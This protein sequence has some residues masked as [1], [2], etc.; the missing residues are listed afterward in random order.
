L[1]VMRRWFCIFPLALLIV[2]SAVGAV[3]PTNA[4][5]TAPAQEGHRYLF[6][7]DGSSGM[8][9]HSALV[10]RAVRELIRSG[11]HGRM[12]AGDEFAVWTYQ[13]NVR[14]RGFPPVPWRPEERDE[15][16]DAAAQYLKGH[17]YQN[18]PSL[19]GAL[20]KMFQV[21]RTSRLLTVLLI[22]DGTQ[23]LQGTP[24]DTY[25]NGV[26]REQNRRVFRM[27]R[28]FVTTLLAVNGQII[29]CQVTPIEERVNLP[30]IPP[31]LQE[32][33]QAAAPAQET[34]PVP[35]APPFKPV[36]LLPPPAPIKPT[37]LLLPTVQP[38]AAEPVPVT[39]T[40]AAPPVPTTP[41]APVGPSTPQP[42]APA[43][44]VS[45]ASQ[46]PAPTPPAPVRAQAV[47]PAVLAPTIPPMAPMPAAS[48]PAPPETLP[49][50]PVTRTTEPLARATDEPGAIVS[51][52]SGKPVPA[53]L[54][55]APRKTST[56]AQAVISAAQAVVSENQMLLTGLAFLLVAALLACIWARTARSRPTPSLIS[57]SLGTET[58]A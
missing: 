26:Y 13:E 8:G 6:L 10:Q 28:P 17:V 32:S 50:P 43:T 1:I 30:E 36:E 21:V 48:V 4:T 14:T 46:P 35:P 56:R 57:Q 31:A 2:A 20:V 29:A 7:I 40:A 12:E 58:D 3:S 18:E 44:A 45:E 38:P 16:A 34:A 55:P 42:A 19:Y 27:R 24:F 22:H 49:S 47:T 9:R 5:S 41:G 54:R 51:P 53:A 23:E 52:V 11:M 15:L 37:L 39:A 25:A 33:L